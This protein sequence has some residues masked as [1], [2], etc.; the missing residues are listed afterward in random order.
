MGH[1]ITYTC[2]TKVNLY[3]LSDAYQSGTNTRTVAKAS[4]QKNRVAPETQRN[5]LL[6]HEIV[7]IESIVIE[8][9]EIGPQ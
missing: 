1:R 5:L 7:G 4:K 8:R 9:T 6:Y 3:Y 2:T